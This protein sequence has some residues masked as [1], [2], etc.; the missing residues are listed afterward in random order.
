M[1][2]VQLSSIV[3]VGYFVT[4]HCILTPILFKYHYTIRRRTYVLYKREKD[5]HSFTAKLCLSFLLLNLFIFNFFQEYFDPFYRF[6]DILQ[7]IRIG[8]TNK[9]F[10]TI[11]KGITRNNGNTLII[12]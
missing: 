12:E 11:A 5:R 8:Y 7:G 2:F 10:T 3:L 9:S 6:F 4:A 1:L